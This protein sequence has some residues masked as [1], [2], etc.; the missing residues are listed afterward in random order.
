MVRRPITKQCEVEGCDRVCTA[1]RAEFCRMHQYRVARYGSTDDPKTPRKCRG[2]GVVY[3]PDRADS[4]TC[5]RA[6]CKVEAKRQDNRDRERRIF[7]ETGEWRGRVQERKNL[8]IVESNR[9]RNRARD[10]E[11]PARKRYPASSEAR[12]ARRRLRKAQNTPLPAE[13]FTRS[14]IGDRDGWV[15]QLCGDPVD[16]EL[17]WP[18]PESQSLDHVVPISKGG[19]HS[20]DNCQIAHLRCNVAKNDQV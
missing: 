11:M 6:E 12:D 4:T 18:D 19:A 7:A 16:A 8:G 14:E 1:K 15:C 5:S 3:A 17:R 20:R 2:C 13:V 10:A 9:G